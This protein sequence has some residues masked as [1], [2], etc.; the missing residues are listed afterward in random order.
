MRYRGKDGWSV[1]D[2]WGLEVNGVFHGIHIKWSDHETPLGHI[3]SEDLLHFTA[4]ED[5]FYPLPE[6]EYPNDCLMKYTGCC[7]TAKDGKHY[8]Y[9]TMRNKN[10]DEKIALATTTDMESFK[11]SPQNP[12]L[13]ADEKIFYTKGSKIDCRDML[14]VY[15][16]EEDTYYGYFAAMADIGYPSP[17]GVIGVAKSTDLVNW[18]D[19]NI[20]Y[21]PPFCGVMEVPDVFYLDGKWYLIMLTGN[22]YGAKGISEDEDIVSFTAYAVS[23]SPA[24]PF[25]HTDDKIFI[26]GN[27]KSGA[28][29]RTVMFNGKRYVLYLDRGKQGMSIALP[30]EVKAVD[31]KL[32]PCYA[33]IISA[34]RT[35]NITKNIT[36][37]MLKPANGSFAWQITSGYVSRKDDKT[38]ELGAHHNSYQKFMLPN[39]KY[40][41][42]EIEC[43]IKV[44]C[45]EIGFLFEAFA[46]GC[47]KSVDSSCISLNF[48]CG[49]IIAYQN[50]LEYN[51]YSK[52]SLDI[53]KEK[54]YHLRMI[55][56]EGVFEVYV[57]DVLALQGPMETADYVVPGFL[58]G[59]G[60]CEIKALKIYELEK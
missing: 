1:G 16:K 57:D 45:S 46:D 40:P 29:C 37:D 26:G 15:V 52:R 21:K 4:C 17:S 30:K 8:I 33:P 22:N 11:L 36:A 39:V 60:K 58:I 34:L 18:T 27:N 48:E 9:Y 49:K 53:K 3:R 20:A 2:M 25:I 50:L 12:V 55:V 5:V 43:V 42:C 32:R 14:V 23:D 41:S 13:E 35:G 54:E 59:N 6:E 24:G 51:P 10:C 38:I 56:A 44:D 7:I 31:G 19:Q 28:V 47:E